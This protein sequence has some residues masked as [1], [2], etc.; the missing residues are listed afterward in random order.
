M[1]ITRPLVLVLLA[2]SGCA[3]SSKPFLPKMPLPPPGTDVVRLTGMVGGTLIIHRGCVKISQPNEARPVTVIWHHE[4]ELAEPP[5]SGL[6]STITG[7]YY[8]FG[9]VV[10]AGGGYLADEAAGALYPAIASRCEGPYATGW[11]PTQRVAP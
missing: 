5:R 9:S 8:P 4:T 7:N 10:S 11:F 2:V 1:S 6:V 3:S